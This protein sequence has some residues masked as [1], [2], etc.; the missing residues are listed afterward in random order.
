MSLLKQSTARDKMVFMTDSADHVTGKTGLTLTITAS[1][2]G[3]AFASISPTVT[4]R[5]NGWY[6]LALTASHTDTAGDLALHVTSTGADPSDLVWQVVSL[7]PG[8]AVAIQTGTGSGQLNISSGVVESNLKQIDGLATNGYNATLKLKQFDIQNSSG[9]A[10]RCASTGGSGLGMSISGDGTSSGLQCLGGLSGGDGVVFAAGSGSASGIRAYSS[11]T[12]TGNA[13][14]FESRNAGDAVVIR[15]VAGSGDGTGKGVLISGGTT[16]GDGVVINTTSGKGLDI[17]GSGG[18]ADIEAN[19][20]GNLIGDVTGSVAEATTVGTSGIT[21]TSLDTT[22]LTAIRN[23][24]FLLVDTLNSPTVTSTT[25]TLNGTNAA[26]DDAYNGCILVHENAAGELIQTRTIVGYDNSTL[27]LTVDKP[28][29]VNPAD[30]DS[31][32]IIPNWVARVNLKKNAAYANFGFTM[33]DSTNHLPATGLTVTAQRSI[34]GGA[35][36]ACS[37]SVTEVGS[38]SYKI[39]LSATD[40]NGSSVKLKF[41]ATGADQQ[42]ILIVTQE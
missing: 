3:G 8:D 2:N 25:A 14:V 27:V 36:A 32:K 34:D 23:R 1:K 20:T 40:L 11:A 7:L 26:N 42:D 24:F 29:T 41:T 17:N 4:E 10:M 16:S 19:I 30:T 33:Y 28:W 9:T 22:A 38:G 37:N 35:F 15:N 39:S 5:G 31:I 12:G 13:A 21:A 6:S 18:N